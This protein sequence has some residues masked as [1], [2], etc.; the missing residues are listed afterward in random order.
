MKK[1][2]I[3]IM[4]VLWGVKEADAQVAIIVNKSVPVD[5]ISMATLEKIY[6]LQTK[7]WQDGT[8]IYFFNIKQKSVLK[9]DFFKCLGRK[10]SE[11]RKLWMRLFLTGEAKAPMALK[12]EKEVLEKVANIPG[13]IGYIG[14]KHLTSDVKVLLIC[15]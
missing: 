9:T 13:A 4:L 5:S 12:T 1:L 3:V 15:N 14:I 7:K 11:L 2:I 10:S 6:T 8:K